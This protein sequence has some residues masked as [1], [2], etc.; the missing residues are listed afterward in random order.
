MALT[1]LSSDR[2]RCVPLSGGPD[3]FRWLVPNTM[4]QR[5]Q[6]TTIDPPGSLPS[7]FAAETSLDPR[8]QPTV[9]AAAHFPPPVH[10]MAV[11]VDA[12]VVLLEQS[13]RRHGAEVMRL[14]ITRSA[15][16]SGP[17]RHAE[18]VF[19]VLRAARLI[20][21]GRGRT[22]LYLSVDAG[23][24]IVYT[25]TL[26]AAA[27]LRGIPVY[28]HH[29]S[30]DYLRIRKLRFAVLCAL[31]SPI[32]CHIVGCQSMADA[33]RGNYPRAR[34]VHILP[35]VYAVHGA[36]QVRQTRWVSSSDSAPLVLGHLSNLSVDKGLEIVF[37][38][39]DAIRAA[40]HECELLIAGPLQTRVDRLAIERRL[41]NFGTAARYLGPIRAEA[42]EQFFEAVNVFLF[43][44]RYRHESF[45]LVVGEAL[46][47]G[48]PVI[49]YENTCLTADVA[50]SAG[51]VLA[52]SECFAER[53]A[54]WISELSRDSSRYVQTLRAASL[55]SRKRDHGAE[56]ARELAEAIVLATVRSVRSA[57]H[58][59]AP[60]D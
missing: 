47:R 59:E 15:S 10:G 53:A 43:P 13:A 45:G 28:L 37:D 44:S 58:A 14:S 46:V 2:D 41:R 40:G 12:F 21:R 34:R 6:R 33:L 55:F 52:E 60:A 38:T 57:T 7:N 19:R 42:R 35:I 56:Q 32:G 18:R 48:C 17:R 20:L 5:P 24:G 39:A 54:E 30:A 51:L 36:P 23:W 31:A 9:I 16:S 50:G 1:H 3:I 26:V 8:E 49:A 29:H 27:R 11:A 4:T 25:L 22:S